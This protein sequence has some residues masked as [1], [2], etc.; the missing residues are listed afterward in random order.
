MITREQFLEY[1]RSENYAEEL[2]VE[3]KIEVFS[4]ALAGSSDITY[5]LL[6]SVCADY[7]VNL[8]DIIANKPE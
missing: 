1:F 7:D 8:E 5:S 3:D 2:S 4:T 6:E